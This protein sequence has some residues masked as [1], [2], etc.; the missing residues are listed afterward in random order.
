MR[1]YE[2]EGATVY[3]IT[4]APSPSQIHICAPFAFSTS[5]RSSPLGTSLHPDLYFLRRYT[6]QMEESAKVR[7]VPWGHYT[8][9]ITYSRI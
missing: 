5:H 9:Q 7:V 6:S 1:S 4:N 3:Y 8:K 2:S